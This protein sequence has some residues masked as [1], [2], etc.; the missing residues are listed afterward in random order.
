MP[1]RWAVIGCGDIAYKRVAPAMVEDPGSEL[2]AFL[3]NTPARAEEMRARFGARRAFSDLEALLADDEV[4]AVYIASPQQRHY[5]ETLRAAAAGKHV[6]CE[7]P[8]ALTTDEC[9]EMVAACERAGVALAVA[10]YRRWYPKARRIK[11]LLDGGGIG[12]PVAARVMIAGKYNPA[13]DDWKHWRVEAEAGGGCM[14][15][16]GSHRLDLIAYWLGEPQSVAGVTGRLCMTY[17]VPDVP[18]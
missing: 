7:K 3:S 2:V 18:R 6:L 14:M 5:D 4:D 16:V 17:D 9:R 15:D 12:T 1:L 13:A 11:E 8:M 10:Y